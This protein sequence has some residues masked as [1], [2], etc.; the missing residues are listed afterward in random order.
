MRVLTESISK[1]LDKLIEDSNVSKKKPIK[2]AFDPSI[3]SWLAN[4]LSRR[5]NRINL[6]P[7]DIDL[8][9]AKYI[10]SEFP[11]TARDVSALKKAG[12]LPIML[13]NNR[14]I[15]IPGVND[16]DSPWHLTG[17]ASAYNYKAY[18]YIPFKWLAD[19]VTAFGYIDLQDPENTTTEVKKLRADARKGS[20]ERGKGQYFYKY[21]P[22][23]KGR[24]FRTKGQ[25]KS[26][27]ELPDP[28]KY[29]KML[30][31]LDLSNYY[32]V[33][34]RYFDKINLYKEKISDGYNK[35]D[36]F[37]DYRG[38]S[39][40]DSLRSAL[41]SLESAAR[42]YNNIFNNIEKTINKPIS[43]EEKTEKISYNDWDL[44]NLRGSLDNVKEYLKDFND[45]VESAERAETELDK[46]RAPK[47]ESLKE[48]LQPGLQK[49]KCSWVYDGDNY[50]TLDKII[51][52][53]RI[54]AVFILD[55]VT[56]IQNHA[57]DGFHNLTHIRI[58]NSVTSIGDGAFSKT[59]FVYMYIPGS[60]K[61][62]GR[63]AFCYC[64]D[65]K[66]VEMY[67]GAT[68]IGGGAFQSCEN[69]TSIAI[70]N[71]VTYVG[72]YAFD[73]CISLK[74]VYYTGSEEDW[75]KIDIKDGNG[76]LLEANIHFNSSEPKPLEESLKKDKKSIAETWS[77]EN[78]PYYR[79][80]VYFNTEEDGEDILALDEFG[81]YQANFDYENLDS[82]KKEIDKFLKDLKKGK[83]DLDTENLD[84]ENYY[85]YP[86][87]LEMQYD[88]EE[89]DFETEE[90]YS[91]KYPEK[92]ISTKFQDTPDFEIKD[93]ALAEYK[94]NAKTVNIPHG[95]TYIG[96]HAFYK[97]SNITDVHIPDTVYGIG[98][99]AF[100]SCT[101][102]K[103]ITIPDSVTEIWNSAFKN[104]SS[105]TDVKIGNKVHLIDNY[106]FKNCSSLTSITIPDG[107]E[108]IG[109]D[110]FRNCTNLTRVIIP[111]SVTFIG[112][113]AFCDCTSLT[114][115]VIGKGIT[116]IGGYTFDGCESLKDVYYTGT[117]EEWNKID[118]KYFRPGD[119]NPLIRANIHFN[120]SKQ[121]SL[122]ED[123]EPVEDFEIEDGVLIRYNG[124]ESEVTI[125][126]NVTGIGKGVFYCYTDLTSVTMPDSI[127]SIENYA[128]E[129]CLNLKSVNIPNSVTRIEKR[130][131]QD[132]QSLTSIIIP[133]SIKNI[134]YR[135]FFGC[136]NLAS[137]VIPNGVK[138]IREDA[139]C[140]CSNLTSVTIGNGVTSIGEW[141]FAYCSK[142]TSIPIP[143]SVKNIGD[144]A[145]FCCNVLKDVYYAGTE[146]EWN[147]INIGVRN[148]SLLDAN[149]HFNSKQ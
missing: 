62:I 81:S 8:A 96:R 70:P 51:S 82:A 127:K 120:S 45:T 109:E 145:F 20:V 30:D 1:G 28:D 111:D 90:V 9:H 88:D 3:P 86:H 68:S 73:R 26:G 57:F 114:S 118:I 72:G 108:T 18:K 61:S 110:V 14:D 106:A 131:F 12:K 54:V 39:P 59:G 128:F 144:C 139:F 119:N 147:D 35:L 66:F 37:A 137:V 80:Y 148:E 89:D 140:N 50:P 129:K 13:L 84:G 77:G 95:I 23:D 92:Q 97:N 115:V 7:K 2:E 146:E 102:L 33:L 40:K 74:D 117:E 64:D 136:E 69:L 27:Y 53:S 16:D 34:K 55:G 6:L 24:W 98:D 79:I 143:T 138:T 38:K 36:V 44:N 94:G 19:Q 43:D 133:D 112:R 126:N 32:T 141:A 11:Q 76:H 47:Q 75:K 135:T 105:L 104:C 56:S 49:N 123:K 29:K 60:V 48:D 25:D 87:I 42:S 121:E 100:D 83:V 46:I 78:D 91:V 113:G 17:D 63:G 122:T 101:S 125:P 103:S 124:S 5:Y 10:P 134:K 22:N 71:S 65:L 130:A 132:C 93:T 85:I 52:K 99:G 31:N 15:Y 67:N 142:L 4:E 116:S 21:D 58:P 107:V 41:N 149:I